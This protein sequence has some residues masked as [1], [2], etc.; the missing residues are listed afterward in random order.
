MSAEP[1]RR[2]WKR[3]LALGL[4]LVG[5][6]AA[7]TYARR[8]LGLELDLSS[9]R[10]VVQQAGIWGPLIFVTIVTTRMFLGVPSQLILVI[11]GACFGSTQGLVY[12]GLGLTISACATFFAARWAGREAV[13]A[14]VPSGL[15][16]LFD[17]AETRL[18]AAFIFVGTAYPIGF[19]TAYNAIAGVTK[20][21]FARFG[22]AVAAGS[23]VRAG[24]YAYFGS[25]LLEGSLMPLLQATAMI[26][27]ITILPLVFPRSRRWVVDLL[28]R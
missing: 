7:G 15:R 16:P 4:A 21:S 18:G 8:E 12:G 5:I 3:P 13:E 22:P 14:R 28:S 25:S 10:P 2:E 19:I 6:F 11:G 23:L 20:L 9:L 17:R 1:R 26:S 24:V 27:A